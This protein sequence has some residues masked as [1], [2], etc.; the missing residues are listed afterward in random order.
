MSTGIMDVKKTFS[1]CDGSGRI[2]AGYGVVCI[3]I[4]ETVERCPNIGGG[5][6]LEPDRSLEG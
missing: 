3:E 2:V 6:F 5:G 1:V 4:V